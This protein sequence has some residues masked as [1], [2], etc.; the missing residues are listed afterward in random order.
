[1]GLVGAQGVWS[2]QYRQQVVYAG[3]VQFLIPQEGVR[4]ES[5][6]PSE[7]GETADEDGAEGSP[8]RKSAT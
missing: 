7:I 8:F 6:N 3:L 5:G 4:W 1:M 2:R